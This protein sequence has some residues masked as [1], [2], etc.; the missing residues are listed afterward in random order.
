MVEDKW[1]K[2]SGYRG[3]VEN[4]MAEEERPKRNG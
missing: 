4:K 3:M 1:Q 2:R